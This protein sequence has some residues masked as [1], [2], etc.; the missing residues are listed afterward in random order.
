MGKRAIVVV[1]EDVECQENRPDCMQNVLP[2]VQSDHG[3]GDGDE[4][5]DGDKDQF[6]QV[7]YTTPL[8]G[9]NGV[10]S[11]LHR[12]T[13]SPLPCSRALTTSHKPYP[14]LSIS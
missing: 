7:H 8:A 3:D 12:F 10:D 1:E 13:A 6:R 5:G 4:N 14:P 11:P 9:A 2:R